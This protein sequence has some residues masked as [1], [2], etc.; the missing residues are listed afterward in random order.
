M[1]VDDVNARLQIQDAERIEKIGVRA[2]AAL[3]ARLRARFVNALNSRGEL[4]DIRGWILKNLKELVTDA[5]VSADLR[6]RK[7]AIISR[8]KADLRLTVYGELLK[9]LERQLGVDVNALRRQYEAEALRVLNNV[10]DKI[11]NDLRQTVSSLISSGATVGEAKE[12]LSER[13]VALGLSPSSPYQ[14]ETIFR[15]QSQVAFAAGRWQADQDPD[16]QEI[17]WGYKYVTVGDNRVRPSHDALEGVTLPKEHEFWRT[18][19]P[20]NGWSCR[21]QAIA[22]FEPRTIVLPPVDAEPDKGFAYNAGIVL[23]G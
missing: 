2:A 11:E 21:C 20:P 16:V 22:L 23:A 18:F 19:F 9:V 4:F 5:M 15:T 10:S 3:T 1:T 17:L 13:F 12:L 6:G 14:I 7:R 8:Q